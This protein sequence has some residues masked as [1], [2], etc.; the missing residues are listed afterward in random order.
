[1]SQHTHSLKPKHRK[2]FFSILGLFYLVPACNETFIAPTN[3][4]QT[5]NCTEFKCLHLLD[6]ARNNNKLGLLQRNFFPTENYSSSF[7]VEVPLTL[8]QKIAIKQRK[9]KFS[10]F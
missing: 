7:K 9:R 6:K 10:H 1:M 5:N 2:F 8:S 3:I 4:F